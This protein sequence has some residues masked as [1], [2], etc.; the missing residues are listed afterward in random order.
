[1]TSELEIGGIRRSFTVKLPRAKARP[2]PLVLVLHGNGGDGSMMREWTTFDRQADEWGMAV[3]YP[4]GHEGSWADGRG[5]TAA[6]EAGVDDVAFLHA[7][8]DW[9]VEQ[10][11]TAP[12]R[13]IVAGMSNGGIM[14]HR[15]ALAASD[16]VA[17]LAAVAAG[18][19]AALSGQRPTHGVSAMLING[20][21]DSLLPITGGY[22]RR[23]GPSGE[24]RGRTLSLQETADRWRAINGCPAGPGRTRVTD[25][26]E[27]VDVDGGVGGTQVV[28][29]TVFGCGHTWPGTPVPGGWDE[30]VSL[31]FDAAEEICRFARPLL[32]PAATRLL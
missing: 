30:P 19:P 32:A 20:T 10:H 16:Q 5:V 29:W 24:L 13:T 2:M 31:E 27:R 17:V 4:D 14:A 9:S 28:A 23:R 1:M 25:A 12:D 21:A 6:D 18:L 15:L 26:S 3:A 7:V 11:G 8:I 22:S